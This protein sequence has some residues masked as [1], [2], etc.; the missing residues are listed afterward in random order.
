M[1]F[2][3]I[4]VIIF[5][6]HYSLCHCILPSITPSGQLTLSVLPSKFMIL[7]LQNRSSSSIPHF[8]IFFLSPFY[9]VDHI[10]PPSRSLF[11]TRTT[12]QA[13]NF[14]QE[15]LMHHLLRPDYDLHWV[16]SFPACNYCLILTTTECAFRDLTVE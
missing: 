3:F 8:T 6:G 13:P 16:Q 4:S 9:P 5:R 12:N 2:L 7:L 11:H 15:W 14:E 1:E 10:Q